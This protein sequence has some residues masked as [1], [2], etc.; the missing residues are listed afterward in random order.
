MNIRVENR[1]CFEDMLKN[2]GIKKSWTQIEL[3]GIDAIIGA[4]FE[5]EL[6]YEG[7]V[8]ATHCNKGVLEAYLHEGIV[9]NGIHVD[10]AY[11]HINNDIILMNDYCTKI[12]II[13]N[14]HISISDFSE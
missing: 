5:D 3:Y 2:G 10:R 11:I 6:D 7:V 9:Y 8:I 12:L 14:K 4:A 13:E 1:K